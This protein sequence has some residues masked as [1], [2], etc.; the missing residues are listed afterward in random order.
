M[1]YMLDTNICIYIINQQ[2]ASY[3]Q[4]LEKIELNH[5]IAISSI[6]LAELQYGIS[7]SQK[8]EQNQIKLNALLAKLRVL[9]YSASCALYYGDVRAHLK[10]QGLIIGSN[11]LFIA[12]HTLCLGATLITNNISEFK[13]IDSLLIENWDT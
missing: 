1:L 3:L 5:E 13:P 4:R 7:L 9:D 6:V 8:K 11:D 2:P 10:K 12:S